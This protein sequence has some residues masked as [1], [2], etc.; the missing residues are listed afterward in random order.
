MIQR[1][2]NTWAVDIRLLAT[3]TG[4]RLLCKRL[5]WQQYYRRL[6]GPLGPTAKW[7]TYST[8]G[9]GA[10]EPLVY[11]EGELFICMVPEF[12]VTSL[13]MGPVCLLNQGRFEEPVHPY[14][15]VDPKLA[16]KC[17]DCLQFELPEK[18]RSCW[19]YPSYPET[20]S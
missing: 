1:P 2:A 11:S 10:H 20:G 8:V 9:G 19:C 6:G 16:L 14:E 4:T 15:Q 3:H 7:A 13:L 18:R 12:L 5:D 17:R